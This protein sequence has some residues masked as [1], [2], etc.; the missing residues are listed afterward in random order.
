M[1]RGEVFQCN[2]KR[3][4]YTNLRLQINQ[5]CPE[6]FEASFLVKKTPKFRS[7]EWD[8]F[9]PKYVFWLLISRFTSISSQQ[10]WIPCYTFYTQWVNGLILSGSWKKWWIWSPVK[11]FLLV[12]KNRKTDWIL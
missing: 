5:Y 10:N 12:T 6:F 11:K 7:K 9:I 4:V 3:S 2:I 1:G 8:N